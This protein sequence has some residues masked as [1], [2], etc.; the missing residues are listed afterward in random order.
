M[1]T[2]TQTTCSYDSGSMDGNRPLCSEPATHNVTSRNGSYGP[3][4]DPVCGRHVRATEGRV[5]PGH[6]STERITEES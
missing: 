6:I 3:F 1:T 2:T 5:Y 4:T